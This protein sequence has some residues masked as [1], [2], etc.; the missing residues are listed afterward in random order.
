MEHILVWETIGKA[1]KCQ[2]PIIHQ[3]ALNQTILENTKG[4]ND[5]LLF[6]TP[7]SISSR[8]R[9]ESWVQCGR[10]AWRYEKINRLLGNKVIE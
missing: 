2:N 6:Q 9:R 4:K 1:Y 5:K 3:T 10:S 8:I 7:A